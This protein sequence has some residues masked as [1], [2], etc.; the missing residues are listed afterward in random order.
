MADRSRYLRIPVFLFG[1]LF[2]ALIAAYPLASGDAGA[3]MIISIYGTLGIF[4]LWASRNPLAH[5]SLI[6]F[7]VW[8]SVA[9][10]GVMIV[11]KMGDPKLL[12]D[13]YAWLGSAVLFAVAAVLAVL[14]P[15]RSNSQV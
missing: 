8:S 11:Q 12:T 5:L 3:Q 9:H 10:G 15:R 4:L 2:T 1:L 7:T 6:W 13:P 14:I